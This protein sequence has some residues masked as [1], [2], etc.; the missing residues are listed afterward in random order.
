[1]KKKNIKYVIII[2]IEYGEPMAWFENQLCR[3]NNMKWEDD[4]HLVKIYTI[5]NAKKLIAKSNKY[6]KSEKMRIN[7]LELYPIELKYL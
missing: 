1:M 3:C 2:D 6:R 7:R 5:A 4:M